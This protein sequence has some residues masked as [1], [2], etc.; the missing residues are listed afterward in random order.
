MYGLF[1]H[2]KFSKPSQKKNM[3]A[4]PSVFIISLLQ[5]KVSVATGGKEL[6]DA[7]IPHWQGLCGQLL[8]ATALEWLGSSGDNWCGCGFP[9]GGA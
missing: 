4:I 5:D 2:D 3:S 6:Q 9:L 7:S 1:V 8:G